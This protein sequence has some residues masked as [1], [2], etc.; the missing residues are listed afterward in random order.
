MFNLSGAISI[1]ELPQC[2]W[3]SP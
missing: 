3:A 1:N 2:C